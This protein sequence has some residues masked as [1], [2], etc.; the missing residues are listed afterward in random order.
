[1][2]ARRQLKI[3][4]AQMDRQIERERENDNNQ[5]QQTTK[6]L[7]RDNYCHCMISKLNEKKKKKTIEEDKIEFWILVV[8]DL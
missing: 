2:F 5:K 8:G 3:L 7:M 6:N 4:N 1:M